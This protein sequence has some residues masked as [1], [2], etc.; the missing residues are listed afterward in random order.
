MTQRAAASSPHTA[1]K[2]CWVVLLCSA[3]LWPSDAR[4]AGTPCISAELARG[5]V[6]VVA[7]PQAQAQ[8]RQVI[9]IDRSSRLRT[10]ARKFASVA[11]LGNPPF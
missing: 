6:I 4:G 1:I 8:R 2:L 7:A 11:S 9:R 3:K 10:V 5:S